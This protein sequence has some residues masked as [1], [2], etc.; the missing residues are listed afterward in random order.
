MRNEEKLC[1]VPCFL[2]SQKLNCNVLKQEG[3][4]FQ[5]RV[6]GYFD[7]EFM[8]SDDTCHKSIE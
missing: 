8:K 5:N 1:L 4:V 3:Q 2:S 6:K 7:V